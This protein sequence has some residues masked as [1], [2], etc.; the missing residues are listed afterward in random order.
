MPEERDE[1]GGLAVA[2][3]QTD[4]FGGLEVEGQ[5][6]VISPQGL[7]P[8]APV[9]PGPRIVPPGLQSTLTPFQKAAQVS[10]P[11]REP[12][13]TFTPS[14][15]PYGPGTV[16]TSLPKLDTEKSILGLPTPEEI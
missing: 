6:P 7:P 15:I 12:V 3:P 14:P 2:E 11:P 10:A 9:A 8:A 16:V 1:F 13:R 4:E 5:A